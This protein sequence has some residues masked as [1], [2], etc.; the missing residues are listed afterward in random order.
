MII[1]FV[2]DFTKPLSKEVMMETVVTDQSSWNYN[3]SMDLM[4]S[5]NIKN[6]KVKSNNCNL[7]DFASS[8]AGAL[9]L[10][11]RIPTGEFSNQCSLCDY[12]S[13]LA[14]NLRAHMK[15]HTGEKSEKCSLCDYASSRAGRLRTHMKTHT[16]EKSNRQGF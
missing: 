6:M 4:N 5:M 9:K 11:S 8:Y 3:K 10:H 2:S 15:K 12:A 14:G 7:N 16:G 1:E 13:S